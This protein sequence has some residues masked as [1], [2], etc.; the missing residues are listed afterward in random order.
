[1]HNPVR[2][3]IYDAQGHEVWSEEARLTGRSGETVQ[4][5]DRVERA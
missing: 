2:V 4:R 3:R 5:G 1:M